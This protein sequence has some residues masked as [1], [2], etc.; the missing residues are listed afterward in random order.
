MCKIKRGYLKEIFILI[1]QVIENFLLEND[2]R[3]KDFLNV[4]MFG[5]D[6]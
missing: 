3:V 1:R 6:T 2:K 4:L 5:Y